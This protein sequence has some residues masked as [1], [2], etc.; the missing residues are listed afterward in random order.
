MEEISDLTMNDKSHYVTLLVIIKDVLDK[1]LYFVN[2][3][4]MP[5]YMDC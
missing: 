2:Q 3:D 1:L 5:T 4:P